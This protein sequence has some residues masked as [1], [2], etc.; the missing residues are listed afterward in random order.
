[1][2]A[3][4]SSLVAMILAALVVGPGAVGRAPAQDLGKF[5]EKA[6]RQELRQI[7]PAEPGRPRGQAPPRESAAP[8]E[9]YVIR[10]RD[11]WNLVALRYRPTAAPRPG[12]M[13][14]ILCHGLTYSAL[15]WDLD[16][17]CSFPRYLAAMGFDVWAVNLRGSGPS[18]KWVWKLDAAPESLID[19]AMWK[20]TKGKLGSVSHASVDPKFANWTLDDHITHD[21]PAFVALVRRH[22]GAAE[23]AWVGHSMGGIVAIGHLARYKNPGIGRLATIGSQVTMPRGQLP[24]EFLREMLALR[25]KQLAGQPVDRDLAAMS[26]RGVQDMFFNVEN[27]LPTVYEALSGPATDVPALGLML[28]YRTLS[29][30]GVLMDAAGRFNYAKGLGNI[31]I[32]VFLSCGASDQ[33]APPEVQQFLHRNVGSADKTLMIFGRRQG[34]SVDA[35]HDD[36]LVGRNSRQ[37]VYPVL[38]RW[39]D[40]PVKTSAAR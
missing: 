9:P 25:Q 28:Q 13:P 27:V 36:A 32:P 15:F 11:G 22:T 14:I 35:G 4:S 40:A 2:S 12:A 33:F 24:Q 39:L 23:V 16:P 1:M 5:L 8:P 10:T 21:V 29:H 20:W 6:V 38:A 30:E 18:Q 31:T 19:S 17:S 3:K 7:A 37:E 34:M 26:R